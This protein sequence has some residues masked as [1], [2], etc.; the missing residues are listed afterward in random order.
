M[1][2]DEKKINNKHF[3]NRIS[4][5]GVGFIGGSLALAFKKYGLA[6]TIIG[7][8]RD[9]T[10][11]KA[12]DLKIIDDGFT[13]EKID[14]GIDGS[15]LIILCSPINVIIE[16]IKILSKIVSSGT[17]ITD[18]GSTKEKILEAVSE[19]LPENVYFIGGH[20][21]AGSERSGVDTADADVFNNKAYILT[22]QSNTPDEIIEKLKNMVKTI[23]SIPY[24]LDAAAHDKIVA[25]VSH[26]PQTVSVA[27]MNTVG[28]YDESFNEYYFKLAGGGLYDMTRIASSSFRI[29]KDIYETNKDNLKEAVSLYIKILEEIKNMIGDKELETEFEKSNRFREVLNN[30]KT[31]IQN[32]E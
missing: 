25:V 18:I 3:F 26:L 16:H 27:L 28:S 7:V 29:W 20:P 9:E 2:S 23:G 1:T 32:S 8:S 21:M 19:I 22:P 4:I 11:K 31:R 10:I 30:I 5:V 17:V 13:Y 12:L 6:K 14:E 24:V 15:S